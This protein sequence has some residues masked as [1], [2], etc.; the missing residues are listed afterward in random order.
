MSTILHPNQDRVARE[1]GIAVDEMASAEAAIDAVEA[2]LGSASMELR[3]HCFVVSV[4]RH[5]KKA[6]WAELDDCE[7]DEKTRRAL[8]EECLGTQGFATSLRTVTKDCRSRFRIV[9]FASSK[10]IDRG[11]LA[12]GTKAYRIAAEV[13]GRR[14]FIEAGAAAP[15]KTRKPVQPSAKP[16]PGSARK[17]TPDNSQGEER[18][19][20]GRRAKRRVHVNDARSQAASAAEQL[21]SSATASAMSEEEFANLDAALSQTDTEIVQQSWDDRRGEERWSRILGILAGAGF[22]VFVA[23]LFL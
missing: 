5:K 7:L 17:F 2:M 21:S 23:L 13:L 18:S 20:E 12:T 19:V 8:A 15:K 4:L 1:L 16:Q 14:G 9:G 3:A 22:F 10:N 6:K 11:V